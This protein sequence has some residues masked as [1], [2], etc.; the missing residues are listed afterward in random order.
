MV[1]DLLA[2]TFQVLILSQTCHVLDKLTHFI[3]WDDSVAVGVRISVALLEIV[4][5]NFTI[6]DTQPAEDITHEELGLRLLQDTRTILVVLI[7]NFI[8]A[9]L[10]YGIDILSLLL[11]SEELDTAW[12]L[13]FRETWNAFVNLKLG[14]RD[15]FDLVIPKAAEFVIHL[16]KE[17]LLLAALSAKNLLHVQARLFDHLV[18]YSEVSGV[19][20][21][22]IV[23]KLLDA[24]HLC[25]R[26]KIKVLLRHIFLD[27]L[28][29]LDIAIITLLHKLLLH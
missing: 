28:C 22:L 11:E 19:R 25:H 23:L 6:V 7:P 3:F 26:F 16:I 21:L 12:A 14:L 10:K 17:K 24:F 18:H 8:D 13:L 5:R 2:S 29:D 9:L 15:L 1:V 4:I 27:L 20:L